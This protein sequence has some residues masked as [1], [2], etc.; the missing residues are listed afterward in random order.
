VSLIGMALRIAATRAIEA[1]G[2]LPPGRVFDSHFLPVDQVAE[3]TMEPFCILSVETITGETSGRDLNTGNR[4][5][6]LLIEI[7]LTR[8]IRVSVPDGGERID[9]AMVETDAG[10]EASLALL[11][12]QV[13]ACLFGRGGGAWGDAFRGLT[14]GVR[15]FVSRRAT[16][17]G[18]G[19]R[20]CARQMILT[21]TPI[22]EPP[23]AVA[24]DDKSPF[25]AFLTTAAADEQT[26]PLARAMREAAEG[27]PQGWPEIWT[28]GAVLGGYTE[29]EADAIGI[30][31]LEPEADPP[32]LAGI[33]IAGPWA[34]YAVEEDPPPPSPPE[35]DEDDEDDEDEGGD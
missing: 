23:F 5:A 12:R 11:E 32:A 8:A 21:L 35:D 30:R 24:V 25:A 14:G 16:S 15:E 28:A 10:L 34:G 2:I 9:L 1:A 6:E 19:A 33:D 26:L 29:D 27:V 7:G 17:G 31:L 18:D 4:T 22:A 20:F 3:G 13:M